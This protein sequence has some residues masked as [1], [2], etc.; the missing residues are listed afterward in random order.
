MRSQ[1]LGSSISEIE[2][3]NISSH[4]LWVYVKGKEY[5]LPYDEYPWFKEAQIGD[6]LEVELLHET[7]LHWP[8]LDVDLE[9][10]CLG[11]P[12]QYPLIYI[13]PT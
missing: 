10:A 8:R 7:H 1:T 12:E 5:F 13:H 3:S 4:G 9:L 11:A 2:I 6:I